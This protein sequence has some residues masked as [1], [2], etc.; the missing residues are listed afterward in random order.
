MFGSLRYLWEGLDEQFIKCLKREIGALRH[1]TSSLKN[2][3]EKLLTTMVLRDL[4]RHNPLQKNSAR[5]RNSD[6][7]VYRCKDEEE[8]VKILE[9]NQFMSGIVDEKGDLYVCFCIDN[10][11]AL[12][13]LKFE[14]QGKWLLNLWYSKVT[15]CNE[16]WKFKE[17][18]GVVDIA[19]DYFILLKQSKDEDETIEGL[20]TVN[21]DET[22]EGLATVIC[23]SWK[24]R[25]DDGTL[26]LPMP[27]E[28]YLK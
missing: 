1:N 22:I 27:R 11:Y 15:F 28:E 8:A 5:S 16:V 13:P 20:A 25:M 14:S 18:S 9:S 19:A 17:K 24:V 7:K 10:Q 4:N 6:F 26:R 21:E 2:L 12:L 3:L 23:K